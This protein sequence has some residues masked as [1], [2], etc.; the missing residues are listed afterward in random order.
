MANKKITQLVN[1][2]TILSTDLFPIGDATTGQLYKKTVAELQAAI[3]GAVIS[4]NA[5]VGTVV[6][7]TD[8]VL[9]TVSPA[10][11]YFTTTRSRASVS[12][13]TPLAY[14]SS[15]GVFSLPV[16]TTS[17]NGYLSS[18]D[19]TTFNG[20]ENVLTFSSPLVRTTNTIS[21]P[22]ATTSVNGYLSSTD[23]TTFNGK[24]GA[25]TLTV[26]G[27][28]GASTLVGTTLNIPTYT[29]AGL[30]GITATFLSAG[31]GI[32]YSSS[33]GIIASTITQYTDALARAAHSF[34][35]GSGAYNSTTGVITIPTNTSQLTNGAAFIT[36]TSL[37][38]STGISYNSTTGAIS[39]TIT[40]Y[41]DALARASL[42][43]TAGS[44]G[45][46]STTGVITIPT[47]T[48]QLTNG[49][50][51]IT[52]ITSGNVTT[53]LGYTPVTNARTLTIQGTAYD[54]TAD[55]TW[56][57]SGTLSG[58]TTNYIPK[59]TGTNSLGN[60]TLINDASG[61]LGLGVT[62][63]AWTSGK[64]LQ[65]VG[66]SLW[67][68]DV[69]TLGL[70]Q[71]AFLNGASY[72]YIS[73][74][75]AS[76]YVQA[77]GQHIWYNAPSGTA[78]TSVTFT[79]AMTLFATGNL[80]VGTTTDSGYKLD[81]N[82]T[83]RISS[84][85]TVGGNLFLNQNSGGYTEQDFQYGG[86]N[87][88]SLYW[89]NGTTS[90]NYY[91]V[92]T[93]KF[94]GAA[95]FSSSVTATQAAIGTTNLGYGN[96]GVY[97]ASNTLIGIANFTSYAQLQQNG[98]DLYINTNLS[99]ATGGDLIFRF[100]SGSTERMRITSAGNV[101]IGTTTDNGERLYVSGA[102]RA[103]GTITANSD[104]RLKKNLERIENALEKV[105]QI[106]GYTYN[107][108]YDDKRHGGVIA[109]EI[110]EVFPEIVNKGNDGLLGVEYGNI[111]ALLI[112]ALKELKEKNTALEARLQA[113]EK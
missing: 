72:N 103:T 25:L 57:I 63:S 18:T 88:A 55:R 19:W 106:S 92:G 108:I 34:T 64:V 23:W 22:V 89:E 107:T 2:T 1:K 62:P 99:G 10:N 50:G 17:A 95:T 70:V 105:G 43:F 6:L 24:Q 52:G 5:K 101:L 28:S 93:H 87:K 98:A 45:Y 104:I 77:S 3:G 94:A 36:L 71:N 4:V 26:T 37:S 112:E 16:A 97:S 85:L 110:D 109:Q 42:S 44:G 49:A 74:A 68:L 11:Q 75:A 84:T 111:S 13:T 38:G 30:G 27:S 53:A 65:T 47:N 48:S 35:A 91:T 7:T 58:L 113:L 60:S 31:A 21:I 39:S 9:E 76:Y 12:A 59:A 81:I 46:N 82:G 79:Q 102:I 54:L 86:V 100:G 20:K 15:T 96:L 40:Q 78:G 56:T 73:S 69:N 83:S 14:N 66:G 51:F 90:F 80:A 33:T 29:L 32:T 8:D 41:T 61:N 67:G